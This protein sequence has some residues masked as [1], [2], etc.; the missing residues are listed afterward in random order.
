MSN[1]CYVAVDISGV[2]T[3]GSLDVPDQSEALRRIREMGLFPTKLFTETQKLERRR[4]FPTKKASLRLFNRKVKAAKLAVFTRQLA[5]LTEAGLPLLRSLRLLEQQEETATLKRVTRELATSIESGQSFSEAVA[6]HPRLFSPL[7]VSLI[8]AGEIG[9]ALEL[10]LK[11]LAEFIEN[12]QAIKG[13]VKAAMFYPC[14]V[15]IVASGILLLLMTYVVPRFRTVFEGLSNGA[16]LP[17]F[18]VFVFT[19][20]DWL[21]SHVLL[22]AFCLLAL[23]VA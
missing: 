3:R 7:Y 18:S 20:S 4:A 2:E 1:Y 8:K 23:G 17:A 15:M 22:G 6:A 11:R 5:T 16:R 10:T 14:A 12:A 19:I 9:G 21:R 13:K